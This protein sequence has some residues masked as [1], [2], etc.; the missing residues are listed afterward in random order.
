MLEGKHLLIDGDILRYRC[1]F[2]MD[3]IDAKQS[4]LPEF[5]DVTIESIRQVSPGS[6][7]E[8]WL[9]G[10]ENFREIIAT[11]RPYKWNRKDTPKP[12][13]HREIAKYLVEKYGAQYSRGCEADDEIGILLSANPKGRVC[14]SNDK[15]MRQISGWHFD[16]IKGRA[17]WISRK[18][19]DFALYRQV[20][21]GDPTDG[22]EGIRG[23]G[24]Q[25]SKAILKGARDSQELCRRVWD[26]YSSRGLSADYFL[27]VF[28]LVYI[29]RKW[30]DYLPA[31]VYAIDEIKKCLETPIIYEVREN[32]KNRLEEMGEGE[33]GQVA[34]DEVQQ[35]SLQV[36]R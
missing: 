35:L 27:E 26:T 1:G 17:Y 14:V 25:T 16:P 4:E 28:K 15:D 12:K 6:S 24:P 10:K 11:V 20:L 29:L 7:F 21:E 9:S 36:P 32:A 8:V 5:I 19:A 34:S 13:F 33:R 2:A 30:D 31:S 22:V 23:I 18:S 3:K